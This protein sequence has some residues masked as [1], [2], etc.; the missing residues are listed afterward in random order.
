MNP[1][2][3]A[4]WRHPW[5]QDL[6]TGADDGA[7]EVSEVPPGIFSFPR[8]KPIYIIENGLSTPL[9][10]ALGKSFWA[11]HRQSPPMKLRQLK[12]VLI[13]ASL[14]TLGLGSALIG[15]AEL[16]ES[17][18]ARYWIQDGGEWRG[19]E[20]LIW[21]Y[22]EADTFRLE[23]VRELRQRPAVGRDYEG[24]R[25]II[26]TRE[27]SEGTLEGAVAQPQ[28]YEIRRATVF[29][30]ADEYDP[31]TAFDDAEE[32]VILQVRFT[33]DEGELE[34]NEIA[35]PPDAL[36]PISH[37]WQVMQQA[38]EGSRHE[39]IAHEVVNEEGET[40]EI[41]FHIEGRQTVR[42]HAGTFRTI[43]LTRKMPG[44]QRA[45]RWYMAEGWAGLPVRTVDAR[46]ERRAE[47]T[48]LEKI[49][50]GTPEQE[51]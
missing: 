19:Y 30:S 34:E 41:V 31:D 48:R 49:N 8:L 42:T 17:G 37:R 47:R 14:P 39:R 4:S 46:T 35:A 50:S 40:E 11:T 43:R 20:T 51:G 24:D 7:S 25:R 23:R 18:S 32:E 6:H 15:A 38:L 45:V 10:L 21:D 5:H 9:E 3:E 1:S 16:P 27:I 36:D 22:P 12:R 28:T 33:A 2:L 44:Q 29:Q 13:L 26:M